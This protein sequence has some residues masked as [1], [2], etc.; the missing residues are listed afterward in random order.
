MLNPPLGLS[1]HTRQSCFGEFL[2]YSFILIFF[3]LSYKYNCSH[4]IDVKKQKD[5]SFCATALFSLDLLFSLL[6]VLLFF[7]L[8][9]F[10]EYYK[11]SNQ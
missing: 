11:R 4:E 1:A 7:K 9:I 3:N 8:Y 6:F 10:G 2:C 5:D